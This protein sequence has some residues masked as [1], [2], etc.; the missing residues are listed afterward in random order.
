MRLSA[1]LLAVFVLIGPPAWSAASAAGQPDFEACRITADTASVIAGCTRLIEDESLSPEI[2]A[3]GFWSRAMAREQTDLKGAMADL[4]EALRIDPRSG[5][6]Y[7]VRARLH[8]NAGEIDLALADTT[9]AVEVAPGSAFHHNQRGELY[10]IKQD[11]DRAIADFEEAIRLRVN[12]ADAYGTRGE[13][14]AYATHKG[15]AIADYT[16][17]IRLE[18]YL[19]RGYGARAEVYQ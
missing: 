9:Q 2:H 4:A 16:Q 1:L 19:P 15:R 8:R 10:F 11:H 13:A 3:F 17:V 18:P 5:G 6:A 14:H 12:Y 7:S